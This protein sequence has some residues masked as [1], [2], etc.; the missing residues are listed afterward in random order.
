MKVRYLAAASDVAHT[1]LNSRFNFTKLK[2]DCI[3]T[4]II[5]QIFNGNCHFNSKH[6]VGWTAGANGNAGIECCNKKQIILSQPSAAQ[7]LESL[8]LFR[9][10]F[11]ILKSQCC[12]NIAQLIKHRSIYNYHVCGQ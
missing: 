3:L 11:S 10:N 2:W 1:F 9:F 4:Q 5:S 8:V 12:E 7:I 6:Q